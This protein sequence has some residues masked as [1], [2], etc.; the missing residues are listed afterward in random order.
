MFNDKTIDSKSKPVEDAGETRLTDAQFNELSP[1]AQQAILLQTEIYNA[2]KKD[3]ADKSGQ[4]NVRT[5]LKNLGIDV[6]MA[7]EYSDFQGFLGNQE[8]KDL[9]NFDE[10]LSSELMPKKRDFFEQGYGAMHAAARRAADIEEGK[11]SESSSKPIVP[12]HGVGGGINLSE[13]QTAPKTSPT[14]SEQIKKRQEKDDPKGY[15]EAMNNLP[16]EIQGLDLNRLLTRDARI[17][18]SRRA[19]AKVEEE[20]KR[21]FEERFP[22]LAK[23]EAAAPENAEMFRSM[24]TALGQDDWDE[25]EGGVLTQEAFEKTAEMMQ[26][27]PVEL[28]RAIGEYSSSL[29]SGSGVGTLDGFDIESLAKLDPYIDL[30]F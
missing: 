23:L 29:K 30:V 8:L 5:T 21:P 16:D 2:A 14:I 25:M 9:T 12:L 15:E 28:S 17:S 27:S 3:R 24:V 26:V 10:K 20:N 6:G 13:A 1:Q 18:L 19:T 22:N 7:D 11:S 4:T